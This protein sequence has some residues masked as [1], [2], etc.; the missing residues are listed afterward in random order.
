M[1]FSYGMLRVGG[2]T[3]GEIRGTHLLHKL[4]YTM[5]FIFNY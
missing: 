5:T 3:L 2:I 4:N 1:T